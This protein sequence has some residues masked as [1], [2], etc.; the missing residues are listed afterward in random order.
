MLEWVLRLGWYLGQKS[1]KKCRWFFGPTNDKK[2]EHLEINWPLKV[3]YKTFEAKTALC[4]RHE[5]FLADMNILR[6]VPKFLGK[7]FY[8]RKKFP[9]P[10]NLKSKDLKKEVNKALSTV[11]LPLGNQGSCSMLRIGNTR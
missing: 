4:H 10:I 9:T 8:S 3:E 7:P 5:I 1:F 6:F 11:F 2:K